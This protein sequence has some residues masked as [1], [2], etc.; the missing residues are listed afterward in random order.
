MD[1]VDRAKIVHGL[2]HGG[3]AEDIRR[4]GH[5]EHIGPCK[6]TVIKA[7][8]REVDAATSPETSSKIGFTISSVVP[9]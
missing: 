8:Q 3:A 2:N 5:H 1:C 6:E 7:Q 9:G 4:D